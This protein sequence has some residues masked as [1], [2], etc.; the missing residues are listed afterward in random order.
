MR[1]R[2]VDRHDLIE[3]VELVE[4]LLSP[5]PG[6]DVRDV[7][8]GARTLGDGGGRRIEPLLVVQNQLVDPLVD[9]FDHGTVRRQQACIRQRPHQLERTEV[10]TQR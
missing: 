4:M 3:E 2:L 7:E 9:L 10:V 6:E 5:R 1:D 8:R